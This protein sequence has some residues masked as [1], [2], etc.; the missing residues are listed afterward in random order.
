MVDGEW[1]CRLVGLGSDGE[2]KSMRPFHHHHLA[3]KRAY[4]AIG[5]PISEVRFRHSRALIQH[6]LGALLEGW[7]TD[8]TD[9]VTDYMPPVP[10]VYFINYFTYDY[11][12]VREP[13][14][15]AWP[16]KGIDVYA[17][18]FK[19]RTVPNHHGFASSI[20]FEG[21]DC[22]RFSVE[23]NIHTN[24]RDN[25][26]ISLKR[27]DDKLAL[28]QLFGS[29]YRA[30]RGSMAT[31]TERKPLMHQAHGVITVGEMGLGHVMSTGAN[32]ILRIPS[33]CDTENG[34]KVNLAMET[35][36]NSIGHIQGQLLPQTG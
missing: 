6:L 33:I 8:L 16:L 36:F 5:G 9:L 12:F 19:F 29:I 20:T 27:E 13:V 2:W 18:S 30:W 11:R 31:P 3:K 32:A 1:V 4:R 25:R 34:P 28:A 23:I 15:E 7:V 10:S 14:R 35:T 24:Q 17:D 22:L 21:G 26:R